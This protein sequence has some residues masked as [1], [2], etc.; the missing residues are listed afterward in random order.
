MIWSWPHRARIGLAW[1]LGFA[2]VAGC[3]GHGAGCPALLLYYARGCPAFPFRYGTYTAPHSARSKSRDLLVSYTTLALA[4]VEPRLKVALFA[5][6]AHNKQCLRHTSAALQHTQSSR[7]VPA[8]RHLLV[9]QP[10]KSTRE[11]GSARAALEPWPTNH[12]N[13]RRSN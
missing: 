4:N 6:S 11:S 7:R 13:R 8:L 9:L 5:R 12:K 10:P 2:E 1:V 3:L